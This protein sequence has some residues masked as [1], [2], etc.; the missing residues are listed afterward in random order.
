MAYE[1]HIWETNEIIT[2]DKLNHIENGVGVGGGVRYVPTIVSNGV[3]RFDI[4]KSELE[5]ELF[6][7]HALIW[8]YDGMDNGSALLA[9]LISCLSDNEIVLYT[10]ASDT[11]TVFSYNSELDRF[12]Y[13]GEDETGEG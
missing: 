6:T 3:A 5:T 11:T 4:S 10:F 7:N 2:A 9:V 8:T 13:G 1:K 12:V